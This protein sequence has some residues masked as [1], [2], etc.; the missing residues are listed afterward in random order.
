VVTEILGK[1]DL[2]AGFLEAQRAVLHEGHPA[3]LFGQAVNAFRRAAESV[4]G[5]PGNL[6]QAAALEGLQGLRLILGA[7]FQADGFAFRQGDELALLFR[8]D[9]GIAIAENDLG[10]VEGAAAKILRIAAP[11]AVAVR[12]QGFQLEDR[13]QRR[14]DQ[15][16]A[17]AGIRAGQRQVGRQFGQRLGDQRRFVGR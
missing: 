6:L 4:Q 16:Q 13:N 3:R 1:L 7:T 8:P 2:P 14:V 5:V 10:N 17:G 12:V 11:G 9:V 15:T